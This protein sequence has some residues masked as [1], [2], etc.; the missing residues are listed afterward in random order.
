MRAVDSRNRLCRATNSSGT[1]ALIWTTKVGRK[2]VLLLLSFIISYVC[3]SP[4]QLVPPSLIKNLARGSALKMMADLSGGLPMEVWKSSV[5]LDRIRSQKARRPTKNSFQV[6]QDILDERGIQGMWTGC[7]ARMVEGFFSGAVLLAGKETLRRSLMASPFMC[8]ALSPAVIGFIAGAGGGATQALVMAPT[9]FLVT[10][11]TAKGDHSVLEAAK[12]VWD[13]EGIRGIYRGSSAVAA[14]QATNWASRQGFTELIR[15]RIS[16][17]GV[18]GE[19]IAG[20]LGGAFS[21]WNTPFEVARIHSQS[22]SFMSGSNKSKAASVSLLATMQ[23][24]AD[25][26][27]IQGLFVGLGPRIVQAC[28]QTVFLVCIPRLID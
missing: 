4:L 1:M 21:C 3:A 16:I 8:K 26:Q 24:V 11:T 6:L 12:E 2:W 28:Y 10:A 17:Q 7:S 9:S 18:P 23:S 5:V 20:C 13:S 19:I 22:K 15:P 27:G 25:Q 14:R